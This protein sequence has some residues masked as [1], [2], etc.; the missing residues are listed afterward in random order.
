MHD[1]TETLLR[2]RN[3]FT[4]PSALPLACPQP[5]N[6]VN[7]QGTSEDCLSMLIFVPSSA[8]QGK[9]PALMWYVLNSLQPC[10]RFF[11][12]GSQLVDGSVKMSSLRSCAEFGH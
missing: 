4:D 1:L 12:D 6:A 9:I 7:S 8:A 11:Q 3:N 2:R 10:Y 5:S